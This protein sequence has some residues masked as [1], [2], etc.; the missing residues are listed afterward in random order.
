MWDTQPTPFR[1][2]QPLKAE[3]PRSSL[4]IGG[5]TPLWLAESGL[6]FGPHSVDMT[7]VPPTK[8]CKLRPE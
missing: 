2:C 4:L 5:H 7:K 6:I 8:G 3:D 1:R